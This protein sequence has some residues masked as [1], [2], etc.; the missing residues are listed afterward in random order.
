MSCAGTPSV[1]QITVPMPASTASYTASAANGAGT[2]I[3]AVFAPCSVTAVDDRIEDG[4][5]LD[6]L[7][8]LPRGHTGDEI[9]PVGAVAKAVEPALRPGQALDDEPCL[10][11]DDDR[12]QSPFRALIAILP[13]VSLPPGRGRRAAAVTRSASSPSHPVRVEPGA[14]VH[15]VLEELDLVDRRARRLGTIS[16]HSASL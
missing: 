1:M 6:V 8:A 4:H 12:H 9:R 11:V 14:E 2:K 15:L 10:G 5:S 13:S 7:A 3:M 16:R